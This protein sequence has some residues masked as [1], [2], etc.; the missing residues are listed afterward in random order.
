VNQYLV[1]IPTYNEA[2]S[3]V[4]LLS[5]LSNL[6]VDVLIVD[7]SSPDRTADICRGTKLE[8][9]DISVLVREGKRGMG[10][11]Y[12]LGYTE[13]LKRDYVFIVQMDADGSHRVEDLVSLMSAIESH[14]NVDLVI[15]SRWTKGGSVEN[16]SK[17]REFLSRGANVYSKICLKSP[18]NDLTAG[19]R[20]YRMDLVR[21]M[22]LLGIESQG[23]S[24]QIEMSREAIRQGARV[25]EVPILFVER[26]HGVSKMNWKIILEAMLKVTAWGLLRKSN[27]SRAEDKKS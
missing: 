27:L 26:A 10:S 5:Q 8:S 12:V 23:Y 2:E 13:A 7:D 11:A 14:T 4:I 18:I 24:F 17:S 19:F 22:N 25:L 3:I 1:V 16:W 15:G 9:G 6:P 21:R 20:I